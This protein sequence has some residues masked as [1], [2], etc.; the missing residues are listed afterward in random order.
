MIYRLALLNLVFVA[1]NK[2]TPVVAPNPT[3]EPMKYWESVISISETDLACQTD[4]DC[5]RIKTN[6]GCGYGV[7]VNAASFD[8]YEAL[9][10]K[11]CSDGEMMCKMLPPKDEV[12]CVNQKCILGDK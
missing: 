3:P 6:C 1:C 9:R 4:S 11:L 12:K 5:A 2:P 10:R 8:T 7:P